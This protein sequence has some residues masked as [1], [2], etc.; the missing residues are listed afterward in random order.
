[1]GVVR[2]AGAGHEEAHVVLGPVVGL[3]LLGIDLLDVDHLTHGVRHVADDGLV[4]DVDELVVGRSI[5]L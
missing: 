2:A 5:L 3:I 4:L 1:V